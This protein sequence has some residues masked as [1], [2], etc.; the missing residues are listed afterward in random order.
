MSAKQ[1]APDS[2]GTPSEYACKVLNLEEK[3]NV[4]NAV[5]GG[6]SHRA[7]ALLFDVGHT[8]VNHIISHKEAYE[9]VYQEGMNVELKYLIPRNILYPEIDEQMW[10]FFCLSR[11]KCIPINGPMLQSEENDISLKHNY[12]NF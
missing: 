11:A 5:E 12:N 2:P 3:I 8:Q 9:M 7:V 4:I 1:K 6:K 10:D